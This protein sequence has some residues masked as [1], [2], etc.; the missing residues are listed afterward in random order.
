MAP[1]FH[2]HILRLHFCFPCIESTKEDLIAA[3]DKGCLDSNC[4][5]FLEGLWIFDS[6]FA[7]VLAVES[8][9]VVVVVDPLIEGR[10]VK[11]KLV[12]NYHPISMEQGWGWPLSP[13]RTFVF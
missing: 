1:Y 2:L 12:E 3:A 8:L 4:S 11:T 10:D 13:S 7:E 5:Y 6:P 9:I